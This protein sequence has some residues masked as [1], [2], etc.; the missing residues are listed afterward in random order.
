[1]HKHMSLR[2]I[3]VIK[4]EIFIHSYAFN[5]LC[6][7]NFF[8]TC[9]QLIYVFYNIHGNKKIILFSLLHGRYKTQCLF[10]AYIYIYIVL[11]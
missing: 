11:Y 3:K 6:E 10:I 7:S 4:S 8:S 1:M 9:A 5:C 2:F